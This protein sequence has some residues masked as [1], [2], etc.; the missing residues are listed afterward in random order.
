MSTAGK[1]GA[2]PSDMEHVLTTYLFTVHI[3]Q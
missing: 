3:L 1:E 2:E